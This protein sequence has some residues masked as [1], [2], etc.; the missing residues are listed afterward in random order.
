MEIS[1]LLTHA[2]KWITIESSTDRKNIKKALFELKSE[3]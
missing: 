1:P 2:V 3:S